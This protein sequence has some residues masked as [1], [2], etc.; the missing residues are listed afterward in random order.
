[1]EDIIYWLKITSEGQ[2]FYIIALASI[3]PLFFLFK[4]RRKIFLIPIVIISILCL[5]PLFYKIFVGYAGEVYWRLL[6]AL[7]V[8][9]ICAVLPCAI[10]EKI[11]DKFIGGKIAIIGLFAIAFVFLGTFVYTSDSGRFV[12]KS[13]N[14]FKLPKAAAEV[15]DYLLTL[16]DNP[17]VVV[18]PEIVH[19]EKSDVYVVTGLQDYIRQYTGKMNLMFGRVG[20]IGGNSYEAIVI[21]NNLMSDNGDC[22]IISEM[23]INEGYP[24]LVVEYENQKIR[25]KA[26]NSGFECIK[27]VDDYVIYKIQGK[28]SIIKKKNNRGQVVSVT[29][30]DEYGKTI[31]NDKGY[32]TIEYEYDDYGNT[33]REFRTDSDG[34]G[35]VDNYGYAGYERH[36][37]F[38]SQIV[39]ERYLGEDGL[40]I[41]GNKGYS[42]VR[43]KYGIFSMTEGYYDAN[44]YPKNSSYGYAMIKRKYNKENLC[45]METYYDVNGDLTRGQNGYAEVHYKYNQDKLI[46]KEMYFDEYRNP[47]AQKAGYYG[48]G[49]KYDGEK[50]I[51]SLTYLDENGNL[52]KRIDGYSEV[53]WK[54]N[55]EKGTRDVVFYDLNGQILYQDFN[56]IRDIHYDT[57]GWSRWMTPQEDKRNSCFNIGTANLGQKEEGDIYTCYICIEFKDVT[58]TKGEQFIFLTQGT[59]D[60]KWDISNV[61]DPSLVYLEETPRDGV[62][63]YKSTIH[64]NEAMTHASEF[65]VGFRCDNWN[66]GSFRV[67]NVMIIKGED[68]IEW[69]PGL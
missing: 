62:Y 58:A 56:L 25:E 8:I 19:N 24:Y 13:F 32:A 11:K 57:D 22:N 14:S 52:M 49:M 61:W 31:N 2:Y 68:E 7:P 35:V 37:N 26:E 17:H 30:L 65:G 21:Y 51:S 67:K 5:S 54:D 55:L 28:P 1:M 45:I 69:S 48:R 9:P 40:P 43:R 23:M 59:V 36:Y 39:M 10:S 66:S 50:R 15:S 60:G 29:T 47:C 20:Y 63:Y 41:E 53:R 6:W 46:V 4:N 3:V 38:K 42:E 64:V 12:F 27:Q 33:I 18:V 44:G 16:E 34:V